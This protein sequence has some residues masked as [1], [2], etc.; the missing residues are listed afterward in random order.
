MNLIA[1]GV[2]VARKVRARQEDHSE[3]TLDAEHLPGTLVSGN[4]KQFGPITSAAT[5]SNN[6]RR[7]N[8]A[9]ARRNTGPKQGAAN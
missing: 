9:A 6:A 8:V 2:W 4:T 5:F 1:E 7:V 3:V